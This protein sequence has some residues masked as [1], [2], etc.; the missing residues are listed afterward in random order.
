MELNRFQTEN[1]QGVQIWIVDTTGEREPY[2]FFEDRFNSRYASFSPDDRWLAYI[3]SESGED[4]VYVRPFPSADGK[5][6][7]SQ[8]MAREPRWA[9][10]GSRLFYRTT[11]GLKYVTVDTSQGFRTS[12][13][14]LVEAGGIGAPF[15]ITYS[16]APD[17]ER[18]LALRP[19][20]DDEA[21]WRVHVILGWADQLVRQ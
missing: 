14:V 18:L 1:E 9:P 21:H 2:P 12:R 4:Q 10:D 5:W 15:N 20:V 6:Q 17:G 16:F 11:E 3:S 7:V 8:T 13:P 19:H